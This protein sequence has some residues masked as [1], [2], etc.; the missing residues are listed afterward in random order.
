MLRKKKHPMSLLCKGK[1][2]FTL[3]ELVVVMMLIGIMLTFAVPR[4][5]RG[6]LTDGFRQASQWIM[7]SVPAIKDRAVRDQH[8]YRLWI[9]ID[10]NRLWVT[11]DTMT[12]GEVEIAALTAYQLPA[13]VEILDIE[14]PDIGRLAQGETF[15]RFYRKGYSDKA[16]I[17]IED[18]DSRQRSFLVEPFLRQ[19]QLFDAYIPFAT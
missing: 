6:F 13:E 2:A 5:R 11:D 1:S 17:H 16:L 15:V 3:V 14:Y 8:D 18:Q 4:V 19:V 7:V 12:E 10:T 9:D